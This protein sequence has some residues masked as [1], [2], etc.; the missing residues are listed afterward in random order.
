MANHL[1]A[2][3]TSEVDEGPQTPQMVGRGADLSRYLLYSDP[4]RLAHSQ[5][6][7]RRA[8]SLVLAVDQE[9]APLLVAAAWLHDIGYAPGLR[10]TGFHPIDGARHLQSIGWPPAICNQVANHSGARFV[11]TVLQLDQQLDAYPFSQDAL[12]D[13]L[14]AADQ[15]TGPH[16]E[17]M[18]VEDR[19]SD[20]LRR[21]G[22]DSPNALAHPLRERYIRAAATRVAESLESRGVDRTHHRIIIG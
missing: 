5:A 19:M 21:H 13:A 4:D 16:G 22:P 1:Q 10:D 15:T 14:T 9:S 3:K 18:T 8:E 17:A 7:A 6:V 2:D 20:M 11:A 12:S